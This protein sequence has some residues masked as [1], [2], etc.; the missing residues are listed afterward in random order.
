[1]LTRSKRMRPDEAANDCHEFELDHALDIARAFHAMYKANA[2]TNLS[3]QVGDRCFEL[4]K[5]VVCVGSGHFRTLLSTQIGHTVLADVTP[6]AFAAIAE[7]LYT[8]RIKEITEDTVLT[9]LDASRRLEALRAETQC[10][11]WLKDH[12][13]EANVLAIAEAAGRLGIPDLRSNAVRMAALRWDTVSG[14][15]GFLALGPDKLAEL[16]SD[17]AL[18]VN[19]RKVFEAVMRWVDHDAARRQD[20]S[21]VL[22]AVRLG[23]LPDEYLAI[24]VA[25]HPLVKQCA[26]APAMLL[27]AFLSK[28]DQTKALAV[29]RR[30][31]ESRG[32]LYVLGGINGIRSAVSFDN[33]SGQWRAQALPDLIVGRR[34]CA[35][36]A[37]E[38][39]L[40]VVGGG[41]RGDSLRSAE[42]IDPLVGP[43][44]VLPDMC[45][46][47][48]G[49]SAASL[50]GKLYVVGG[51]NENLGHL[52]SYSYLKS[53]ECYIPREERWLRLPDMSV[54]R[55]SCGMASMDGKLYV[56]G[57][58]CAG[59]DKGARRILRT[60]ECFEP[61]PG[62]WLTLPSM[63]VP[64]F[65]CGVASIDGKLYV[66][67]GGVVGGGSP[68]DDDLGRC[69]EC[70]DPSLGKWQMLPPMSV[71]RYGCAAASIEGK[72]YVVGGKDKSVSTQRTAECFDPLLGE[73]QAVPDLLLERAFCAA[74][75]V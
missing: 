36:A 29:R 30:E 41:D 25:H 34:L 19:E 14:S 56:V 68:L 49:C 57:G 42:R 51:S 39:T 74:A 12:M 32:T 64:R 60:A 48:Y 22:G 53:A 71:A 67:G 73:W 20:L 65:G 63:S 58:F 16:V 24:C 66:V 4:H 27:S 7:S 11:Q 50:A 28:H 61:S 21:R 8:G 54:A 46:P 43:W 10:T 37:I 62:M 18:A 1:M 23:L 2:S 59:K 52:P 70:F 38:G 69:A 35:A 33:S 31:H 44:E 5:E 26:D 6:E 47:R 15:D 17:D 55:R 72:L 3:V 75:I 45:V 40:Y 9:L 13:S